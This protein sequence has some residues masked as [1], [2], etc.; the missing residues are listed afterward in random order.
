M[1]NATFIT[2]P[3]LI[4]VNNSKKVMLVVE[5]HYGRHHKANFEKFTAAIA[6]KKLETQKLHT[7]IAKI[8]H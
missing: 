3:N 1:I 7:I 2:D 8:T 4:I 6:G 5:I